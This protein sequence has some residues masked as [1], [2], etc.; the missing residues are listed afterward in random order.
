MAE[1]GGRGGRGRPRL[2]IGAVTVVLV[3]ALASVLYQPWLAQWGSTAAERDGAV[4]GDELIVPTDSR[5][6][7]MRRS[8]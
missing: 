2:R 3:A 8:P 5:R 1:S 6:R 4:A 7:A